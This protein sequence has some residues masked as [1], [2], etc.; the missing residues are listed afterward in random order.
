[1]EQFLKV[2]VLDGPSSYL[3]CE[4]HA[5]GAKGQGSIPKPANSAQ[6]RLR[7]TTFA[8]FLRSCVVQALSCGDGPCHS[9]LASVKYSEYKKV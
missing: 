4:A 1:M 7:L 2:Q 9:L 6:Y 8:M 3:S 5:I